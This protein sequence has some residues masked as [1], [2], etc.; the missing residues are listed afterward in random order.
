MKI[1]YTTLLFFFS[2]FLS[3][4]GNFEISVI[5]PDNSP[6]PGVSIN[7]NETTDEDGK[8]T[9]SVLP[10]QSFTVAY[11]FLGH[12]PNCVTQADYDLLSQIL[13]GTMS[14][15][16]SV[17][18]FAADVN[19]DG[20][21]SS[22]DLT[23]LEQIINGTLVL[24]APWDFRMKGF[25]FNGTGAPMPTANPGEFSI[26]GVPDGETYSMQV[27]AL[28]KG[29]VDED[30]S[31]L[32]T[33]T[34]QINDAGPVNIFPNPSRD[35]IQIDLSDSKLNSNVNL[36]IFD[37]RGSLVYAVENY[38]SLATVDLESLSAGMYVVKISDGARS[39]VRRLVRG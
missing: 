39:A 10:N 31:C 4:Q 18:A 2:L 25:N 17:Q 29:N 24:D 37:I 23:D 30:Y 34:S 26:S 28:L 7:G 5:F 3:A 12:E 1:T 16:S 9:L 15:S 35:I 13:A 14:F 36:Q 32:S 6:V 33:S 21:N 11:T 20:A 27:Y 38:Q 19:G 8:V 22:F